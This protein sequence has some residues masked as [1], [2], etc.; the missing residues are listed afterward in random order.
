V[1]FWQWCVFD[2]LHLFQGRITQI[3]GLEKQEIE[4]SFVIPQVTLETM[5]SRPVSRT[6][7]PLSFGH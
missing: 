3:T 2:V 7:F 5:T 1:E 6:F 4:G